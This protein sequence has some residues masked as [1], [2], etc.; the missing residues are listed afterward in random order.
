MGNAEM[1]MIRNCVE[2]AITIDT[3][4]DIARQVYNATFFTPESKYV[5]EARRRLIAAARKVGE[6]PFEW[7]AFLTAVTDFAGECVREGYDR[8][9]D[10]AMEAMNRHG[11]ALEVEG[12]SP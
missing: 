4:G 1:I 11:F 7:M 6:A 10:T 12:G 5:Q 2:D 3:E 8:G 9:Y